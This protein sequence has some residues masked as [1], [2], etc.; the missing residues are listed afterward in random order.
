MIPATEADVVAAY[1]LLLGR[2]GDPGG[3]AHHLGLVRER[4]LSTDDLLYAFIRSAE[5]LDRTGA[6]VGRAAHPGSNQPLTCSACTSAQIDSPVFRYWASRLGLKPGGLHRKAWEWCFITQALY[7][8]G[9]LGLGRRGLGFAVGQEPLTSLFAS[10]GTQILATDLDFEHACTEGWVDGQQHAANLAQ[11]NTAG[12]C[13]PELFGALVQFR[14]VDMRDLPADVSGYDFLWSSC[15]F[16]HLGSLRLGMQ[17]V[18]AAMRC[19]KPGGVAVHTTELNLDSDEK[20][21]ETG[22]DV[23]YRQRD[24]RQLA[25]ELLAQG[26]R[27]ESLVFDTGDSEADRYVDEPPYAGKWHLKLRIGG[28]ASTSFGIIVTRNPNA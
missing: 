2:E 23:I 8:R 7:E 4:A 9:V 26:H 20:T 22:H 12:L 27:V 10:M 1:R 18:T 24:F 13:S 3:V 15:A 19:L 11:L 17:F 25:S 14:S 16:E 21:L 6:I 5:F 28:F